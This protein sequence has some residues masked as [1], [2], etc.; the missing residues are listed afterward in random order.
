[1]GVIAELF[2]WL[3]PSLR[4]L[5]IGLKIDHAWH[6]RLGHEEDR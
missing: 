1:M 6:G 3:E 2:E 5:V 4:L